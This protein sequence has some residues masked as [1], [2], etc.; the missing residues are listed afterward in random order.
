MG[1]LYA[2]GSDPVD[3]AEFS[4]A[5]AHDSGVGGATPWVLRFETSS[6]DSDVDAYAPVGAWAT[7]QDVV[8]AVSMALALAGWQQW[9]QFN[10]WYDP[11]RVQRVDPLPTGV[12]V[13]FTDDNLLT[14]NDDQVFYRAS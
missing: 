7:E 9:P 13:T 14:M 5:R 6:Q 1:R 10:V 4:V 12:E 11:E 2:A 8:D 3:L